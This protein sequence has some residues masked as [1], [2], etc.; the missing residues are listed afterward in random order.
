MKNSLLYTVMMTLLLPSLCFAMKPLR[1]PDCEGDSEPGQPLLSRMPTP[2]M[3]HLA[4]ADKALWLAAYHGNRRSIEHALDH[5]PNLDASVKVAI[6]GVKRE[7][8]PLQLAVARGDCDV[9][10]RLLAC[11]ALCYDESIALAH[12]LQR[13]RCLQ[14]LLTSCGSVY[15]G[16]C[17]LGGVDYS[18]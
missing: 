4:P 15:S 11:G 1:H 12:E 17:V 3:P 18:S 10:R 8:T 2:D 13:E 7:L 9:V 16:F 14:I 6:H 5:R